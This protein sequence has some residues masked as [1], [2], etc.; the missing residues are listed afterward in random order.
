VLHART[1]AGTRPPHDKPTLDQLIKIAHSN[2]WI[3]AD[4]ERF[5]HVLRQYRNL[6]HVA[7]QLR[8][9][10]VPDGDTFKVCWYVVV[11]ALND[12]AATNPRR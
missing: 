12:L 7:A 9:G 5:S 10:D 1:P 3:Q 4:A 6:V 11:A 2:R 8:L